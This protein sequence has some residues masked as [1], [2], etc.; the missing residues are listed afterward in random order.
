MQLQGFPIDLHTLAWVRRMIKVSICTTNHTLH[1][2]S[3]IRGYTITPLLAVCNLWSG[4]L[5]WNTG[6]DNWTD[7]FCTKNHFMPSN[8]ICLLCI[9]HYTSFRTM[10]TCQPRLQL[11][12][13]FVFQQYVDRQQSISTCSNCNADWSESSI[14]NVDIRV[15]TWSL[16]TVASLGW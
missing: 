14:H 10:T 1:V 4:L 6:M 7:L 9:L 2:C 15:F 3:V 13:S 12:L 8:K 11:L 16:E 5:E